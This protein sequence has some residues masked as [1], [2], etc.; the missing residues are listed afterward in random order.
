MKCGDRRY[1]RGSRGDQP[2]RNCA[3]SKEVPVQRG[4]SRSADGQLLLRLCDLSISRRPAGRAFRSQTHL[5]LQH[6]GRRHPLVPDAD[7]A[8]LRRDSDDS[9]PMHNR[10]SPLHRTQLLVY[11]VQRVACGQQQKIERNHPGERWLRVGG[12]LFAL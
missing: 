10:R 3:D 11:A 1:T 5:G 8:G 6:P 4:G 9:N 7:H 2:Q 12:M